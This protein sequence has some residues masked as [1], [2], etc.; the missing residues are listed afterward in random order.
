MKNLLDASFHRLWYNPLLWL[1]LTV[2]LS[3]QFLFTYQALYYDWQFLQRQVGSDGGLWPLGFY[4]YNYVPIF[5]FLLS[6]FVGLYLG[7]EHRDGAL[8]NKLCVGHSRTSYYLSCLIPVVTTAVLVCVAELVMMLALCAPFRNLDAVDMPRVLTHFAVALAACV[9]LGAL[10][11]LLAMN[12]SNRSAVV[13]GAILGVLACYI[14]SAMLTNLLNRAE[15]IPIYTSNPITGDMVLTGQRPNPL[16]IG[17]PLRGVIQFLLDLLPV[18]QGM[19]CNDLAVEHP[20]RV[21]G[22][23]LACAALSTAAGLTLFRRKDLK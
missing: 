10:L 12:C 19:A 2:C 4:F 15:F 7:A 17:E 22:Y 5:M 11:T 1:M 21:V 14:L 8:R 13:A 23:G 3:A 6:A 18:S 9:S 16:Y 20:F